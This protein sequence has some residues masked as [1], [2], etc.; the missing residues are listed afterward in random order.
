MLRYALVTGFILLFT[1][2]ILYKLVRTTV[3]DASKWNDKANEELTHTHVIYPVRGDILAA[4]GTIL[5][6]NVQ[7]YSLFVDYRADGFAINEYTKAIP[8]LADSLAVLFP[9]RTRDEWL[10]KLQDPILP[11]KHNRSRWYPLLQGITYEQMQQARTLPFLNIKNSNRSGLIEHRRLVRDCPYGEMARRSIGQVGQT[12]ESKEIH[13]I[14]GLEKALD[15]LLYGKPG[16]AKQVPL[17]KTIGDWTDIPAV[18][19]YTVL[20]TIDINLQDLLEHEL[21][22]MLD[23]ADAEWGTAMIMEVATGDIKAMANLERDQNGDYIEAYNRAVVAYEPGS[24]VKTISMLIAL[25]D[26]LISDLNETFQIGQSFTYGSPIRDSH[27]IGSATVEGILEQSSNIGM[28]KIIIRGYDGKCQAFVDRL[29]SIGL[30]DKIN[31][32]IAEEEMVRVTPTRGK[33]DLANISFGYSSA[34]PPIYTLSIYNAIANDGAYVRPRLV[35]GLRTEHGD[36]L[37]EPTYVRDRI[38]S[39]ENAAKLR[40]MLK[41]VVHGSHGTARRMKN[42]VVPLAGKT[43]TANHLDMSTGRYDKTR[44]RL[45]FCGFF[46]ADNPKYS[47]MVLTFNP[48]GA[49]R[50][51]ALSSGLVF[52]NM[53]LKMYSRGMFEV[54]GGDYHTDAPSKPAMAVSSAGSNLSTAMT[55]NI[56]VRSLKNNS[57]AKDTIPSAVNLSLTDAVAMLEKAGYEVEFSGAGR[58][59]SQRIVGPGVIHLNLSPSY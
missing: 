22:A 59:K 6:T 57:S 40:Q 58:V 47:M 17:T 25:E 21:N 2:A 46:P 1:G 18:D 42:D 30:F 24:V 7:S 12:K 52:K 48:K 8:A 38:C 19:G 49:Y 9:K 31:S 16:V 51:P 27:Y 15:S 5:A 13:G 50:G 39:P 28:T 55:G 32:G 33:R 36:T 37:F 11:P 35:R 20:S 44:N 4:D 45:A 23:S 53:A 14:S 29:R 34:I 54:D 56:P 10:K 41:A 43:G 3:V 26:G